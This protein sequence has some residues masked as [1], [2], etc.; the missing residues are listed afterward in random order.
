MEPSDS[1]F[2]QHPVSEYSV[3]SV[4][5]VSGISVSGISLTIQFRLSHQ[6]V[7][8]ASIRFLI[9]SEC[10][11]QSVRPVSSISVS[12]ILLLFSSASTRLPTSFSISSSANIRWSHQLVSSASIRFLSISECLVQSVQLVPSSVSTQ[13]SHVMD[14]ARIPGRQAC[15]PHACTAAEFSCSL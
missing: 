7:G 15:M 1:R 14:R 10:S 13:F 4:R 8:S 9:I 3:H 5:P 6:L 11:V 12:G 2:S